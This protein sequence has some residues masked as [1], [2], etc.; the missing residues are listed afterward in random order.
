MDRKTSK[1]GDEDALFD[2]LAHNGKT[3]N[4]SFDFRDTSVISSSGKVLNG[5]VAFSGGSWS[6]Q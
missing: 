3:T 1:D 4:M 6:I 5:T 2:A